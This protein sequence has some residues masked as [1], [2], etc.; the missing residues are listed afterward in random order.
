MDLFPHNRQAYDAA[1][2]LLAE[3]GKA[4]VIHPTGTGK[5]FI[6]FQLC[7][8]RPE[9]RVCWLSPSEYIWQTQVENLRKA[10]ETL[11]GNVQFLTYARLML[12]TEEERSRLSPDL[13][14]LDEFHRCGAQEWGRGVEALLHQFPKA[15]LLGLSATHIRYLDQQRNMADELFDGCIA[16]QMT[17]SQAIAQGVLPAPKYILSMYSCS[18]ALGMYARR[19]RKAGGAA[20][21]L[22]ERYLDQL[23]RR[24]EQADGVDRLM[25]K[26][27]PNRQGKYIVFCAN[28]E[29][30]DKMMAL[31]PEWFGRVDKA[32]HLYSVFAESQEAKAA[33]QAFREDESRHL[34]LLYCIDMLNEGVHVDGLSGVIL[35]R[36]TVSPI[37]YKQQIGRALSALKGGT[38][39]IVD[40]VNNVQNLYSISAVRQ[41]MDELTALYANHHPE[42]EI[43]PSGFELIDEMQDCRRLFEQLEASLDASW[44]MMYAQARD[45]FQTHGHLDVPKRY[46]TDGNLALGNWLQTQR[47]VRRGTRFGVLTQEQIAR[48]DAIGMVW[49][50]AA[51]SGW[52]N[53]YAHAKTYRETYG[54][55]EV[56]A[57]YA[58]PDGFRLG[59]WIQN[60][61]ALYAGAMARRGL[62][63]AQIQSLNELGM[64]WSRVD[65]SFE[66]GCAAAARYATLHGNLSVP[67]GY[68]DEAGFKLGAWL[69]GRRDAWNTLSPKKQQRLEQ[70]G[71]CPAGN[72]AEQW[73]AAFQQAGRY[74]QQF[75]NLKIPVAYQAG[76]IRLGRWLR[77]QQQQYRDGTLPPD[78]ANR[79]LSLGMTTGEK[80]RSSAAASDDWEHSFAKAKAYY[81]ANGHLSLPPGGLWRWL[82]Q[83]RRAYPTGLTNDQIQRLES[84]G[85]KWLA[86]SEQRWQAGYT[87]AREY[88]RQHGRLDVKANYVTEQGYPLGSWLYEQKRRYR[89][90]TLKAE[91]CKALEAI[92]FAAPLENTD[93]WERKA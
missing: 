22:A 14:I 21:L 11:P 85:M 29:H 10:G 82:Q 37:L 20:R 51:E 33:F 77:R 17:L 72:R 52:Q 66:R 65:Y 9:D 78:R 86:P 31:A 47:A 42:G 43:H 39:V 74:Q 19:A 69:K 15:Q 1:C 7:Q 54:D 28:R 80:K 40:L 41:E 79:L 50:S 89:A 12:L 45:Y 30:M 81:Q 3:T 16:H 64:I 5:S 6:G 32:P 67:A 73:E 38:P 26:H 46:R 44:D 70:L 60:Q 13:I 75:G 84:I 93:R 35:C 27:L 25:E 88:Y 48:L 68:A 90:G 55:L 8:D 59:S 92:G 76:G 83:Q 63:S 4:A 18:E 23:R 61:R 53:G 24:L 2:R 91:R 56:P 49:Q 62:T 87:A 36:P 58:A 57:R 71:F 34:K